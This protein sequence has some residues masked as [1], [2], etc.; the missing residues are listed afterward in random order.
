[1]VTPLHMV[2]D[3]WRRASAAATHSCAALIDFHV[4]PAFSCPVCRDAICE[5]TA[6]KVAV[7]TSFGGG[8]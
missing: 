1:M 4:H 2:L 8:P 3:L 5:R 6:A 7:A